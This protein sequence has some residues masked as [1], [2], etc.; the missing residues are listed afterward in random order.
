VFWVAMV[1]F[2]VELLDGQQRLDFLGTFCCLSYTLWYL[3]PLFRLVSCFSSSSSSSSECFPNP[4][5]ITEKNSAGT[6]SADA[7]LSAVH[8]LWDDLGA[9][10]DPLRGDYPRLELDPSQRHW[11]S[12][13]W[14]S[15]LPRHLFAER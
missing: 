5:P 4:T 13:R 12:G 6:G 2:S 7:P 8:F 14:L 9:V 11:H 1:L 10:L 15:A 3:A